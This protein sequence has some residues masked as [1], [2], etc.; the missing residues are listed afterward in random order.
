MDAI[1]AYDKLLKKADE[2]GLICELTISLLGEDMISL[3]NRD[4][5]LLDEFYEP[6]T[7]YTYLLGYSE[8][9]KYA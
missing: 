9:L 8:G 3:I 1:I 5:S 7:P 2:L 6:Y 4:G